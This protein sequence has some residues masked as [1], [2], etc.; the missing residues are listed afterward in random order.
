M[1]R[2]SGFICFRCK[3]YFWKVF[4]ADPPPTPVP[5]QVHF[6]DFHQSAPVLGPGWEPGR[7]EMPA[8]NNFSVEN[9][10]IHYFGTQE[11]SY[12]PTKS[13]IESIRSLRCV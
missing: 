8:K 10:K 7:L 1:R 6:G 13:N 2:N 9:I 4:R 11:M 5:K 3:I 12:S